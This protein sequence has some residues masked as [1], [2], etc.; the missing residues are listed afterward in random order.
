M[1]LKK[2]L[3]T[4]VFANVIIFG[5]LGQ[6]KAYEEKNIAVEDPLEG[7]NRGV[8]KFNDVLDRGVIKPAAKGYRYVVPS[9][10]RQRIHSALI[11]LTEPVTFFNSVFQGDAQNA[12]TSLWRFVINTTWGVGGMHDVAAVAGL[13]HRKEDFG[14]TLGYYGTDSGAYLMLP[15]LGPSNGRDLIGRVTDTFTDPFNYMMTDYGIAA[16]AVTDGIDTRE[17]LLN[18]TD[19]IDRISFDPYATIRSLYTQKRIDDIHNGKQK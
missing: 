5:S 10:C 7:F 3:F 13:A 11:N 6:A 14:Q 16:V 8:Y 19:E 9:Q 4:V 2:L 1:S 17:D 18:L 15:I 12:F